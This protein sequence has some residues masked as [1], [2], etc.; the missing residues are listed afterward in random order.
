MPPMTI[1]PEFIVGTI[2]SIGAAIIVLKK[3]GWVTFGKPLERRQCARTCAEHEKIVSAAKIAVINTKVTF[4]SLTKD[5]SS[6][7]EDVS[8]IRDENKE[9]IEKISDLSGY[10]RGMHDRVS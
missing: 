6:L 10:V 8:C 1:T 2:T 7:K 3:I 5:I 4:D 9:I